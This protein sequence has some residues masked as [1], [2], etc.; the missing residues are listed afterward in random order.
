MTHFDDDTLSMEIG[1]AAERIASRVRRTPVLR[2]GR[3]TFGLDMDLT[4]KLE[5]LQHSGTFKARGAFNS[6]LVHDVPEAGVIAASGGNHGAAVAFAAQQLGHRAEI[7]VPTIAAPAKV[8][9]L[10]SY[11]AIVHQVGDEFAQT[12]AECEK[13]AA[14][15]GAMS[16][17][18]YDQPSTVF[19]QGTVGREFESDAPE[20][21]TVLVAVGGGGLIGGIA[22]W[23]Q[24]RVRVVAVE[25]EGT[26]TMHAALAAHQPV[27]VSVSG[28]AAD[29]LGARRVGAISFDIATRHVSEAVLVTDDMT[30]RACAALWDDCRQV[31]EPAAG[32]VLAAL[33]AGAYAPAPGERVGLVICGAN[34][35]PGMYTQMD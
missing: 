20:L 9:R 5:H 22:G 16:V 12:L 31:V 24:G 3:G 23:L 2:P 27:D 14:Q 29:A 7:F 6:L 33:M 25:T 13:R 21:D 32:S 17:H 15:T 8:A 11:N 34:T 30:R 18:A 28:V 10:R 1:L 35:Q 19:G 4:L 26:A